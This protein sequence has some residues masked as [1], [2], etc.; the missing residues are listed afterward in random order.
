M[1]TSVGVKRQ[2]NIQTG[3]YYI[4]THRGVYQICFGNKNVRRLTDESSLKKQDILERRTLWFTLSCCF[5][6]RD[7]SY[8]IYISWGQYLSQ[9]ALYTRQK[10]LRKAFEI[11]WITGK[12]IHTDHACKFTCWQTFQT[13][14]WLFFCSLAKA[15]YWSWSRS[16]MHSNICLTRT[17]GHMLRVSMQ[18]NIVNW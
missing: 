12:N 8:S 17:T 10:T 11:C 4:I 3:C 13:M 9:W 18:Q 16:R 14:F 7:R 1:R 5:Q 15:V 6:I 2:D